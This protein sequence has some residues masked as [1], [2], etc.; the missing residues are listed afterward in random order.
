KGAQGEGSLDDA[1][2]TDFQ[3]SPNAGEV[4]PKG[5]WR[6]D[7]SQLKGQK[8]FIVDGAQEGAGT[9]E[10]KRQMV[11]SSAGNW[12][13]RMENHTQVN[14]KRKKWT[15]LWLKKKKAGRRG[16][17]AYTVSAA[18]VWGKKFDQMKL[19][20][21]RLGDHTVKPPKPVADPGV[22]L[23]GGAWDVLVKQKKAAF[24][25]RFAIS[26]AKKGSGIHDGNRIGNK[27]PVKAASTWRLRVDHNSGKKWAPSKHRLKKKGAN[28][29]VQTEDWTD[30]DYNDLVLK[31]SRRVDD[32]GGVK[33]EKI[34][35][36][37]TARF[38]GDPHFVGGDGG[39]FDVQGEAGK[40][41]NLLTDKGLLYHGR[42]D[43]WGQGV[44]VVGRT[45][46]R[47]LG[48]GGKS[49]II[50]EPKKNTASINGQK[51]K[52]TPT[53]TAD[54]GLTKI[55]GRDL[56]THTAEGYEII[57]HGRGGGDRSYIDAEVNTGKKGVAM[58]GVKP[59]GLLGITFD[60]GSQKRDGKK[61]RGAQ[62]EG[63]IDG[64][65]T[66]YEVGRFT[67][68]HP[69][70]FSW[71]FYLDTYPDL[72]K[73]GI[74]NRDRALNHWKKHGIGEGRRATAG[75]CPDEYLRMHSDVRRAASK[76]GQLPLHFA[77]VHWI[78]YGKTEGRRG[79]ISP[80]PRSGKRSSGLGELSEQL[81]LAMGEGTPRGGRDDAEY[82]NVDLPPD[83]RSLLKKKKK[84]KTR[85]RRHRR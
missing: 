21:T 50:F 3:V 11:V 64:V 30:N 70:V 26:G 49:D 9:F 36:D 13:V 45:H 41:Y 19:N 35:Q 39:Q 78:T 77:L 29:F 34:A 27:V 48:K 58:D 20:I 65:Y 40:T 31:I 84:K 60:K 63:A 5:R 85:G 14:K 61:G 44:T 18:K 22:L 72:R 67:P 47:L 69:E 1:H 33:R 6:V 59:G 28:I 54:G 80:P 57:Q 25:Q 23:P 73:A 16:Q 42:F 55:S 66:D 17:Q 12:S 82:V 75:F 24:S 79:C 7:V 46:L 32:G 74:L 52:A 8:R 10:G 62:G 53:P 56:I 76:S 83:I 51:V 38:W 81:R 37:E 68:G 15:N 71:K 4:I 2:Y 43:G